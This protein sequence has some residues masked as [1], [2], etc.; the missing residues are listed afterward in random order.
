MIGA[1][2]HFCATC[3][4]PFYRGQHVAVIGGGNSAGEEGVFLTRFADKVTLL[5][6]GPTMKASKVVVDKIQESAKMDLRLNTEVVTF[7]GRDKLTGVTIR[8][9]A[10]GATETNH[11]AGVFVFI[12][13]NPNTGWLP[14]EIERDEHGF[15]VTDAALA[16]SMPGVFAAGDAR[17]GAT[18][19]AASAVGEG[20]TV[21]LSIREYLKTV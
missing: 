18:K 17:Q 11:P 4:G 14:P 13:L 5:V 1:G 3:D 2:V 6:R 21:A 8:D 16:T 20:A 7:E 9:K 15:I 10:S 12:G 19:Q